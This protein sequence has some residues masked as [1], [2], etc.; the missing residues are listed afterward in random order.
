MVK[1]CFFT[2]ILSFDILTHYFYIIIV[3]KNNMIPM[4]LRMEKIKTMLLVFSGGIMFAH[5]ARM[6]Y[7][8]I[9]QPTSYYPAPTPATVDFWFDWTTLLVLGVII[10]YFGITAFYHNQIVLY[11]HRKHA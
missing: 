10:F 4:V 7:Q 11:E 2:Q 9:F 1:T 6:M 3:S 5:A 8:G